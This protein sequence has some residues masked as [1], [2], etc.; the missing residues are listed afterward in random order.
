[1]TAVNNVNNAKLA[2][3]HITESSQKDSKMSNIFVSQRNTLCFD[4]FTTLITKTSNLWTRK[5]MHN[6]VTVFGVILDFSG[7]G[8]T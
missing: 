5:Y 2:L 1:M 4:Y 8:F 3:K 7:I 6:L